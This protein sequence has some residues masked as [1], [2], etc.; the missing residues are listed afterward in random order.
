[1]ITHI[2]QMMELSFRM[3][4]SQ[5]VLEYETRSACPQSPALPTEP[6]P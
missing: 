2:S 5:T 3:M 6:L 4:Q 1:M